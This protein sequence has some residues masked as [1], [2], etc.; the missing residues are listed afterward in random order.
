MSRTPLQ[1]EGCRPTSGCWIWL[2]GSLHIHSMPRHRFRLH[3]PNGEHQHQWHDRRCSDATKASSSRQCVLLSS[4]CCWCLYARRETTAAVTHRS[5]LHP[6]P[7]TAQPRSKTLAARCCGYAT[8]T[9]PLKRRATAAAL[10]LLLLKY[11]AR[12]KQNCNVAIT[13]FTLPP[14]SIHLPPCR[15]WWHS[16]LLTA[17]DR[18]Q[19]MHPHSFCLLNLHC[20][21]D[22]VHTLCLLRHRHLDDKA[23]CLRFLRRPA[24]STCLNSAFSPLSAIN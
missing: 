3:P 5:P 19:F 14:P 22:A 18:R 11:V 1:S 8:K 9:M 20:M 23:S 2:A 12:E 10:K 16:T 15:C 17:A 13:F 6:P 21:D 7:H 24:R 4:Q